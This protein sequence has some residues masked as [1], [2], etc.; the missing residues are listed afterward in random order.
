MSVHAPYTAS[1]AMRDYHAGLVR[2][3]RDLTRVFDAFWESAFRTLEEMSWDM[4][5]EPYWGA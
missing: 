4:G 3:G 5:A 2:T 1:D